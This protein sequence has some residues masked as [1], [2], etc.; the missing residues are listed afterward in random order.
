MRKYSGQSTIEYA[1][2]VFVFVLAL[3]SMVVYMKRGVQG[4]YRSTMSSVGDQYDPRH[5]TSDMTMT[6]RSHV[7]SVVDSS[8]TPEESID[9]STTTTDYDRT[10]TKGT[11]HLGPMTVG[12]E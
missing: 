10:N 1:I 6:H 4:A 9:T 2:L 7:T 12:L 3:L 5:T 11:E 8:E